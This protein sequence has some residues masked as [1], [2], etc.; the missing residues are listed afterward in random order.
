MYRIYQNI[1]DGGQ[2][3]LI[4]LV[5][6]RWGGWGECIVI[7]FVCLSVCQ[8]A[9]LKYYTFDVGHVFTH[10]RGLFVWG[11]MSLLTL[12]QSYHNG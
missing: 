9:S 10:S 3:Q 1:R 5:L 12:Y 2:W 6:E 7:G 4:T 8:C 11:F